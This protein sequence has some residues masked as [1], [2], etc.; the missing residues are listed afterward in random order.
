MKKDQVKIQ[1]RDVRGLVVALRHRGNLKGYYTMKQVK[2][3]SID[4]R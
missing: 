1:N 2:V 4:C 3:V